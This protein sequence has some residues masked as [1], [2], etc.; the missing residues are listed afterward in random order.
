VEQAE[1]PSFISIARIA[2]PRGTRGEVLA[3]LYS[4]FP[5]RFESLLE[6]WVEFPDQSRERQTIEESWMHKNRLVLKFAGTDTISAA[7]RFAG[8]WLQVEAEHA[9]PLPEGTYFDHD[10]VGCSVLDADGKVLG[11]VREVLRVAGNTQLVVE[12]RGSEFMIPAVGEICVEVSITE[13]QIRV[14]LP[15]GLID[16][17]E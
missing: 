1:H 5:A 11:S 17:N 8:A 16:L 3:D 9:F 10:L 12:Q 2:R 4:D 15:E 13:K 14:N 6:V 7:E